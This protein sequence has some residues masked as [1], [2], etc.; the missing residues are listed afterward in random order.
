MISVNSIIHI[1]IQDCLLC[2]HYLTKGFKKQSMY[3]EQRPSSELVSE[4]SDTANFF[5]G[6]I[7]AN[8][9]KQF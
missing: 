2:Q 9:L 1:F 8:N 5:L 6:D 7:K 3:I 4:S